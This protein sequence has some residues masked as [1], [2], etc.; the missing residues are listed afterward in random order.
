M[1]M[2]RVCAGNS[3]ASI[4]VHR[5][6]D[7]HASFHV[8]PA[9]DFLTAMHDEIEESGSMKL[10]LTKSVQIELLPEFDGT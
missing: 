10:R 9:L 6:L 2:R 4:C 3:S 1:P 7:A 5:R 8:L